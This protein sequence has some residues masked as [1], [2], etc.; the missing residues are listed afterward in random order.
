MLTKLQLLI[1]VEK[2]KMVAISGKYDVADLVEDYTKKVAMH[3]E[4]E[5]K[6][7]AEYLVD[8]FL[9]SFKITVESGGNL[10]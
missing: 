6:V 8:W 10:S 3:N 4:F 9:N 1:L 7:K 5:E 2:M